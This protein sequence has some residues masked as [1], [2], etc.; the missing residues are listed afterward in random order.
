MQHKKTPNLRVKQ[1]AMALVVASCAVCGLIASFGAKAAVPTATDYSY[2]QCRGSAMPY[3][4]P[5]RLEAC[6][7]SLTP[8]FV[9]HVGRHGAR[10]PSSDKYAKT[11]LDALDKADSLRTITPLGMRMHELARR[12][13]ARSSGRWGAL[14][15]LGIAEQWG[16]A[17]RMYANYP[18]L[19]DNTTI[20]AESSYVPRCVMSMYSF[21]HQI[22]RLNNRVEIDARSGRDFS[23]LLRFF[24]TDADYREYVGGDSWR[25]AYYGYCSEA[26]PLAPLKRLLGGGFPMDEIE[27]T[28]VAMA[29][30]SLVASTA[31]AGI[32]CDPADFFTVDEFNR[33]WSCFNL[34]QYLLHSSTT[35]SSVASE[36][37]SDLLADLVNTTDDAVSMSRSM[38]RK[39]AR[40]RFGHAETLMPLLAL[41][42]MPGCYYL[43]NYFDTVALHWR[44]FAIV[45][46]AAN[47]QIVLFRST[48]DRYYVRFDL[49]ETPVKL[50]DSPSSPYVEWGAARSYLMRQIPI[51][52]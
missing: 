20:V 25:Q 19:F 35:L 11:L 6:P 37:A 52:R 8:V 4:A 28:S 47:L 14:D 49:N 45:P 26:L 48:T 44:D 10:Y 34:R 32:E 30:Y 27:A 50:V 22:T 43:T 33:L 31:A 29:E 51:Y 24:D 12:V 39:G 21:L 16:I 15:S 13:V 41:M 40:L 23:P 2:D 17:Q 38:G 7:D 1:L 36:V 42:R 9:N 5:R 46:M 18:K 3:N